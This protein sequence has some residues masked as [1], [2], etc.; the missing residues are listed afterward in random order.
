VVL[1]QAEGVFP[2]GGRIGGR[3]TI[4]QPTRKAPQS[5]SDACP[6]SRVPSTP[7]NNGRGG[8]RKTPSAPASAPPCRIRVTAFRPSTRWAG[9][10]RSAI[11]LD[12]AAGASVSGRGLQCAEVLIGQPAWADGTGLRDE[13]G[14]RLRPASPGEGSC[15]GAGPRDRTYR[16]GVAEAAALRPPQS[17]AGTWI[18]LSGRVAWHRHERQEAGRYDTLL[19]SRGTRG[20]PRYPRW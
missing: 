9:R 6:V 10:G 4:P 19:Q 20:P 2:V 5:I 11:A 13:C 1:G 17:P 15:L 12:M 14:V 3:G 8:T 18:A 7:L 16:R